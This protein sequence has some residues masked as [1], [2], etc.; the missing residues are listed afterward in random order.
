[1]RV[2]EEVHHDPKW[3][4]QGLEI[5]EEEGMEVV[6]ESTGLYGQSRVSG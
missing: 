5:H 4:T 1:M 6:Y 3:F 2:V